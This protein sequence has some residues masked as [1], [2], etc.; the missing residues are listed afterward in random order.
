MGETRPADSSKRLAS[1]SASFC[2]YG[3]YR[4]SLGNAVFP[5]RELHLKHD[6]RHRNEPQTYIAAQVYR[7]MQKQ[8]GATQI[9]ATMEEMLSLCV[10]LSAWHVSAL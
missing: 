2:A 9:A 1:S 10:T 6:K 5:G 4:R 7:L 3:G 8:N